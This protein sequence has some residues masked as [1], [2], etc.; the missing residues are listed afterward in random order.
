MACLPHVGPEFIQLE[1]HKLKALKEMIMELGGV[2]AGAG[3]PGAQ[4]AFANTPDAFEYGGIH[5][6]GEKGE[7]FCDAR[8][9]SWAGRG[10][11]GGGR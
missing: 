8:K 1:V 4:G 10:P 6:F 7:G 3:Q 11:Y 2:Q 5:P 9:G